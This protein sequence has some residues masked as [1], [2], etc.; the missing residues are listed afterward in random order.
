[1]SS[2]DRAKNV[3]TTRRD[4]DPNAKL[5]DGC[6][7]TEAEIAGAPPV[8]FEEELAMDAATRTF[9]QEIAVL[10]SGFGSI[11]DRDLIHELRKAG[12]EVRLVAGW[13][14]R[15]VGGGITGKGFL[16]HHTASPAGSGPA[17]ALGIVTHGRAD[18]TGPLANFLLGRNAVLYV[19]AAGRCN[20]AGEGG[21]LNGIPR[22]SG[23][24]YFYACEIENNGLGEKYS[25]EQMKVLTILNG[26]MLRR[27]N[28]TAYM[29][30]GHKEW[31]SRKIDPSFSMESFRDRVRSWMKKHFPKFMR[32]H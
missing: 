22:D 32:R 30:L 1:M 11:I 13:Q 21:P 2:I 24:A 8:E 12:V 23:N 15:S 14:T 19:V 16:N 9:D 10:R 28:R 6:G 25:P 27:M 20:H 4:K 18:L 3:L 7:F 5:G 31:T 26:L 17:P 29:S